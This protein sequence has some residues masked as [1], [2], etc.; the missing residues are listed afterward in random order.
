MGETGQQAQL[1]NEAG[2]GKSGVPMEVCSLY[3]WSGVLLP[4]I[5]QGSPQPKIANRHRPRI[6]SNRGFREL[7][8]FYFFYQVNELGHL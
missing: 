3:T 5:T 6:W 7:T 1:Q 2:W 4:A 8:I